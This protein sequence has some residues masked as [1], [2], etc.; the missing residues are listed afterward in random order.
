VTRRLAAPG[1]LLAATIAA[2]AFAGGLSDY[3]LDLGV[4]LLAYLTIAVAWNILGGYGGQISLGSAAFVGTGGYTSG[5]LLLHTGLSWPLTLVAAAVVSGALAVVLSFALLRLRGD[6]FAVGS[7]AAAIALQ[8]FVLNWSWAGGATGIVLPLNIPL[9]IDL[10]RVAVVVAALSLACGLYVSRSRFG[11]RLTAVRDNEPAAS[12][13]GVSV[14]RHRLG[15]L[16]LASVLTGLAGAVIAFQ[17]TA[18]SPDGM[19][20]LVWSLNA[21][22]MTIVGGAGTFAGPIIGVIVVYYGLT[23]QFESTQTLSTVIEGA[24]IIIV[25]RF[26]PGGIWPLLAR[27]A[28]RAG[29]LR[30]RG[31]SG[32]RPD[33]PSGSA[34]PP[35]RPAADELP[36]V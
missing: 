31:A 8:A 19:F 27:L 25:V 10:F 23:K 6:Y 14:Y 7:L 12:G 18:I 36:V 35:E 13:L 33:G 17:S 30:T 15:A 29:A 16:V 3:S 32:G 20:G 24:L 11:L 2:L 5:L 4:T 28:S 9:G 26:A 1:V 34:S 21:L 22:L